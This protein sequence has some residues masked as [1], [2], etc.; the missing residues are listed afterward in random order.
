[1]DEQSMKDRIKDK[2]NEIE[3]FAEF[4]LNRIPPT[5][6]EYK[7]NLEKKAIC[8]RYFE[9]IVEAA[10]DLAI[11]L[12]RYKKIESP[13]DDDKSFKILSKNS[14][15]S[16]KLSIRLSDAKGMR[17]IIAHEYGKINDE[18]VFEA[19]SSELLKDVSEFI[20]SINDFL[21]KK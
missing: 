13:E 7:E 18:I 21:L 15:I 6:K 19:I 12:I 2:I 1:M 4:L 11:L 5:V 20:N 16:E 8:E 9:K 10:V 17:N 14:I 3:E